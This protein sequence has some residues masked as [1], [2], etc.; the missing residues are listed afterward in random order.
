[1]RS[2][3]AYCQEAQNDLGTAYTFFTGTS[4][5]QALLTNYEGGLANGSSI[6]QI[7][8]NMSVLPEADSIYQTIYSDWGQLAPTNTELGTMANAMANIHWAWTVVSNQSLDQLQQEASVYQAPTSVAFRDVIADIA[9]SS[10]QAIGAEAN[11]LINPY[12]ETTSDPDEARSFIAEG[13]ENAGAAVIDE[14]T[15][16]VELRE[17]ESENQKDCD[18]VQ[19]RNKW[20]DD[21]ISNNDVKAANQTFGDVNG[22]P[23]KQIYKDQGIQWKTKTS[24]TT[25]DQQGLPYEAWVQSQLNPTQ[26]PAGVVWLQDEKSNWKVFD[27]WGEKNSIATSDKT[28]N[29]AADSYRNNPYA[30]AARVTA[31]VIKMTKYETDRSPSTIPLDDKLVFT[32]DDIKS[33][34]LDLAVPWVEDPTKMDQQLSKE[35]QELCYAYHESFNL[36]APTGK[37][38]IFTINTVKA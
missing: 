19:F 2:V 4:L 38:L 32:Q 25:S 20:N 14:T 9:S 10:S 30:V 8:Q 26:N 7:F 27:H 28:I 11:V 36:V 16:L 34:S 18:P 15:V 29:L 37:S 31:S 24:G 1:M 33:Y 3:T 35:W 22:V 17:I 21:V 6:N 23:W 13:G 5:Q 12:L